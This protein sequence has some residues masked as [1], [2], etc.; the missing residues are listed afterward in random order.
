M[1]DKITNFQS[2]QAGLVSNVVKMIV[3]GRQL[4]K[5]P[6]WGKHKQCSNVEHFKIT[7]LTKNY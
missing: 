4:R 1:Y 6:S 3:L 5:L 2:V 7:G